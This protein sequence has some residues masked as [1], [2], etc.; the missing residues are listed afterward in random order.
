MSIPLGETLWG[1]VRPAALPPTPLAVIHQAVSPPM[2]DGAVK[3]ANPHGYLDSA[4]DIAHSLALTGYPVITPAARP[5][6]EVDRD[7]AFPDTSV[8]LSEALSAGAGLIWAN[9]SLFGDHPLGGLSDRTDLRVVGQRLRTVEEQ[10]NKRTCH[11][12]C[13][14][15]GLAVPGQ[16]VVDLGEDANAT[17]TA[18]R[19]AL[20]GAVGWDGP[21]ASMVVKPLRG[22]GSEGVRLVS[23][24]EE[25]AEHVETLLG[26]RTEIGAGRTAPRFGTRFLLEQYLPGSEW[27]VTVMPAG[28][29]RLPGGTAVHRPWALPPV[30]RIGHRAGVLPYSGTVPVARNSHVEQ[31]V[32]G[33]R[34]ILRMCEAVAERMAVS[35]PI[36]IDCRQ[37]EQGSVRA[38]DINLKPNMTGP[39]RPGRDGMVNLVGMAAESI[40]WT[41]ADLLTAVADNA[42]PIHVI[43]R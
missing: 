21:Q 22:R 42:V 29:Y 35:A 27:T 17:G 39:G 37:D 12:L 15:E 34:D 1:A 23:S 25:A 26:V 30:A 8:G 40:G 14:A 43:T 32:H 28:Q 10:E 3:P 2:L 24:V 19:R 4:A 16:V 41:Y 38:F 20:A 31:D 36:R 5:L 9:T 13:R 33:L 7:W 11:L 18:I 6:A